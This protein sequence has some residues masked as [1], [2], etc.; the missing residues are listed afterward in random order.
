MHASSHLRGALTDVAGQLENGFG[1]RR[2]EA[3][4]GRFEQRQPRVRD[5]FARGQGDGDVARDADGE[6][7]FGVLGDAG[8]VAVAPGGVDVVDVGKVPVAQ[9]DVGAVGDDA[10][11]FAQFAGGG[12][13]QG[14]V[15][16]V[17]GTGD[18]LPEV[19][20]VGALDQED[21]EV[22]GVDDDQDG[23]GDFVQENAPKFV[24]ILTR[25]P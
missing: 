3:A 12:E 16:G 4:V 5:V 9:G 14:F 17:E 20:A 25:Y 1:V 7:V 11:F 15:G 23:D 8:G 6:D 10:G 13:Q 18:G 22:G 2:G 21:F 19:G 24:T